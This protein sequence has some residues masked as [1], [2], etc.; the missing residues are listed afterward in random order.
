MY[1]NTASQH[2]QFYAFDSTTNAP[3]TG[4]AANITAYVSIDG[5]AATVLSDTSASEISSTLAKGSYQ[6]DLTQAET[7]GNTLLFS[8]KSSTAN[9]VLYPVLLQ[10][11]PA[12]FGI[13]GGAA[14]GPL[15]AGA[16]T[17]SSFSSLTVTTGVINLTQIS[18]INPGGD[19]PLV[20]Q[21]ADNSPCVLV[22]GTNGIN[23]NG[24]TVLSGNISAP[25]IITA[26]NASNNLVGFTISSASL[27]AIAVA[28][29]N[30]LTSA[31]T[32][33]GSIGK[34][35]VQAITGTGGT[36]SFVITVTDGTNPL[37][38]VNFSLYDPGTTNLISRGT[39]D[40]SGNFTGTAPLGTYTAV[41]YKG[42]Y[43]TGT[44]TR[45]VTGNGTGT[46]N[47]V[48]AMTIIIAPVPPVNPDL[49]AVFGYIVS[50]GGLPLEG[51]QITVQAVPENPVTGPLV[52]SGGTVVTLNPETDQT[53]VNGFFS[54]N[55]VQSDL[56]T[57]QI[58]YTITS[59]N[60][61]IN[62]SGVLLTGTTQN[63]N[64]L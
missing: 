49:C 26:S 59:S 29:W 51:V 47:S 19:S 38:N 24:T 1:K 42:N 39:T 27:T 4:D 30:R 8:A 2:I 41:L 10:T 54:I 18:L 13:A 62:K 44:F 64:A 3:K 52:A 25:G 46:L 63:I 56:V 23:L 21:S 35:I 11:F 57:P 60:G 48:M 61:Q 58:T 36:A 6:F 34:A 31:L 20:I 17:T 40:A 16:N 43:V 33:A 9:V 12:C 55:V 15:I 14:G 45:T 22:M 37:Q 7:N 28:V 32:T 50:A 53:D 5:G